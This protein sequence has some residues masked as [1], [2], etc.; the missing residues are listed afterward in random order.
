VATLELRRLTRRAYR[1]VRPDTPD[2]GWARRFTLGAALTGAAW[3]LAA[4]LLYSPQS[5]V[6]QIFLPFLLAGMVGGSLTALTG[7][8]PAFVAFSL[9]AL[10]PYALRLGAEGDLA[11][12]TMAALVGLYMIGAWFMARVVN[13]SLITSTRLAAENQDLVGA[14]SEKSAQLEA[15]FNHVN[16]GVAV[17]ERAS[18]LVTWNPR[19]RELHGYPL[20]L[21][22]A[23]TPLLDF[24]RHDL[25]RDH[26]GARS[27]HE[28]ERELRTASEH[29]APAR[30]E[31]PGVFGRMLQVERIP[32]PGGGFVSTSTDITERKR[33]EQHMLHLAQHDPLTDLPNR[34]LFHDRLGQGM[35]RCRREGSLMAVML[36]DLDK[37]KEINDALGHRI[38]DRALVDVAKRLRAELRDTDTVARIGGDEFAL[39]LPGLPDL[40]AAATVARKVLA[41][42]DRPFQTDGRSFQLRASIGITLFPDDGDG[43]EQLLQNADLAM[44]SAKAEGGG[45]RRF[46]TT[47]KRA[48]DVR[49]SLERE[50]RAALERRQLSL[51]YQ[52]QLDLGRQRISGVEALL[53]WRHP[54]LGLIEPETVIRVAETT[55]LIGPIGEWALAE[56]CAAARDWPDD[57]EGPIRVAVNC[58]ATQMARPDLAEMVGR[59]LERTGLPAARLELELTESSTLGDIDQVLATLCRLRALGVRLAL[60]D[61]GTGYGSLSHLKSFPLDA[62]K[63]DRSFVADLARA[64]GGAIVRSLV[65]LAHRLGLRVIAE[66]V[67]TEAQRIALEELGCDAIQGHVVSRALSAQD[68]AAWLAARR[69]RARRGVDL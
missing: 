13:A 17:F 20:E 64:E 41:R 24:L 4:V 5:P 66:G 30:F 28:V 8:M 18:R 37:F 7:Y 22:R 11:S 49:Q 29:P 65:E 61:F 44:Y 57:R 19:H 15:T 25:S 12:L 9:C 38:G 62:L 33:A 55:G 34:L 21:Y 58:S 43:A 40:E 52:P 2:R 60:D 45:F 54:E 48:F 59:T 42:L 56:A 35:A 63:I 47:I 23:G 31:Q 50:L 6:A 46:A 53:R 26:G 10:V 1:R 68:M 14:L 16:Q 3:G 67:E 32:M 69:R 27:A 36:V 39:I 51:E